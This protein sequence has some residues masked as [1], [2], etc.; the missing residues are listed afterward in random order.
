[1]DSALER[2]V[3]DLAK[4]YSSLRPS[5][6]KWSS[7]Q[8]SSRLKSGLL[9]EIRDLDGQLLGL[10]AR[11]ET[12]TVIGYR[13]ETLQARLSLKR[14][15]VMFLAIYTLW[16]LLNPFS[17]KGIA[18]GIYREMLRTL[19]RA[20]LSQEESYGELDSM[21]GRGLQID[22]DG[23]EALVF[24]EFY[25]AVF[26]CIDSATKSKLLSEYAR[27]LNKLAEAVS[28]SQWLSSKDLHS[29]R[30]L[31]DSDLP[32]SFEVWM[33]PILQE[34]RTPNLS[35]SPNARKK[36]TP[37]S[38]PQ[39]LLYRSAVRLSTVPLS[40]KEKDPQ[41]A[42]TARG[43][44]RPLLNRRRHISARRNTDLPTPSLPL[45][46]NMRF[47]L[48]RHLSLISPL[49]KAAR[50]SKHQTNILEEVLRKRTE[51]ALGSVPLATARF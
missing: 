35:P 11:P 29:R 38:S 24:S 44:L 3:M 7:L 34:F 37:Q 25:H 15:E 36:H 13:M 17:L 48:L 39:R 47:R 42:S 9:Y 41:L 14:D 43:P 33:R 10:I 20:V 16:K 50:P 30:H 27:T 2:E 49:S 12:G 32:R 5:P 21:L 31:T 23:H 1:M 6:V 46:P 18:K 22:F 40:L 26:A 8:L 45:K 51:D 19:H 28:S 4:A